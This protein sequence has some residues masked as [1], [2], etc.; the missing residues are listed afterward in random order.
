MTQK[1]SKPQKICPGNK[2]YIKKTIQNY[3]LKI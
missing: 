3:D 1:I 2:E